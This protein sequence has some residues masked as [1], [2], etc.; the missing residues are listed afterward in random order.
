MPIPE[1]LDRLL[2]TPGPTGAEGTPAKVWREDAAGFASVWQDAMGNSYA[3]VDGTG[4]GPLLA[5]FGHIDEIGIVVTHASDEGFLSIRPIGG[6]VSA[7]ML[8]G[9]RVEILADAGPVRGIVGAREDPSRTEEKKAVEIKDLHVDAGFRSRD[10]ALGRLRVGDLGVI[11]VEPLELANERVA[12]RSL[13]NRIGAYVVLEVVRRLVEAGGAPGPVVAVA[14]VEEEIGDLMGARTSA[15][16]L[17]PGAALAVD[18]TSASD[19]PGAK[20]AEIGEHKL[21]G[22][23]ALLRGMTVHPK[24]FRLLMDCAETE[25]IA[26]S[27]EVPHPRTGTDASGVY[28]SRAGVPTGVVSVPTRYIHTPVETAE[29]AD[30]EA[31]VRL[32]VAFARRLTRFEPS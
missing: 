27:V 11:A 25:G 5:L 2:R 28:V 18:V 1:L 14:S 26:V 16:A 32:V 6:G 15:W 24:V 10:E 12:S 7:Q 4:E 21:G 17:E 8:L 20:A 23:P 19:V 30:I 22:G 31:V 13:D 29:L 3:R 9:Q